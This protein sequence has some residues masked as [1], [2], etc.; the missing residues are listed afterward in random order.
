ML[1]T[2]AVVS[3]AG[4]GLLRFL[5]RRQPTSPADVDVLAGAVWLGSLLGPLGAADPTSGAALASLHLVV[6]A[7]VVW[8]RGRRVAAA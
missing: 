8:V 4:L 2:A 6:G 1:V 3:V 5:E 7:A